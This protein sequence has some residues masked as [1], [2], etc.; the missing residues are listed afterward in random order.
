M[1]HL[2]IVTPDMCMTVTSLMAQGKFP[3]QVAA[4]LHLSKEQF[5]KL[6]TNPTN[7]ELKESFEQGMT[8]L[9]AKMHELG[10][11]GADGRIEK[12]KDTTWN[13]F[14]QK[15]FG[16]TDKQELTVSNP[17]SRFSDEEIRQQK[18]ELMKRIKE[19]SE[20]Q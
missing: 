4:A 19:A 10:M 11:A 20:K 14:M 16:W 18:D 1:A 9:E 15:Y 13:R 3:V 17:L 12:F 5:E 7:V 6:V 8:Q 2:P